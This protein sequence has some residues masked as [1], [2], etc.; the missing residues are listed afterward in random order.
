MQRRRAA[1]TAGIVTVIAAVAGIAIGANV[2]IL[3]R[4]PT[5]PVGTLTPVAEEVTTTTAAPPEVV[6]LYV[7][8]PAATPPAPPP[9]GGAPVVTAAETV[10][11]ADAGWRDDDRRG[12]DH[13][14]GDD[15]E[16]GE[17][18]ERDDD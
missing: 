3:R 7:D 12:E 11:T 1:T 5:E 10:P 13:D 14:K 9:Q 4:E 8:D 17:D 2:G 16:K 6:T 15:H 18:H